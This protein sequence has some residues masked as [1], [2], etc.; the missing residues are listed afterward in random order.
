MGSILHYLYQYVKFGKFTTIFLIVIGVIILGKLL[1]KFRCTFSTR[2]TFLL[3]LLLGLS[4]RVGWLSYSS[5]ITLMEWNAGP[6][7]EFDWLNINAVELAQHGT[8]FHGPDGLPSGRRPIGYPLFLA[9]FYKIFGA[10]LVVAKTVNLGLYALTL[11]FLFKMA[12]KIFGDPAALI[13]SFLFAIYPMSIYSIG[14]LTDEHL[15]LPVWYGGLYLIFRILDGHRIKYDWLWLGIIFGYATMVRTHSIFMPFIVG[16]SF[17]FLK[18]PWK[19]VIVKIILVALVMQLINLPWVIRNYKVWKV[20]VLYTATGFFVYGA[21]N[22]TA[23][24]EGEGH[25]PAKGEPGYSPELDAAI[26]SGNEGLMHQIATR[27]MIKWIVNHPLQFFNLGASRL[28]NFMCFNRRSGIWAIWHQYYPGSF[29]PARPLPE[30][31]KKMLEEYAFAFYYILFFS[32]LFG[33]ILL[34]RRGQ[35]LAPITRRCLLILGL[36]FLFWFAEHMV[37]YPD[38]KYRFPLEPLMIII[39]A[40]FFYHLSIPP[41]ILESLKGLSTNLT[42]R[43]KR[44]SFFGKS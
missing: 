27:E 12:K 33:G 31:F 18:R 25:I 9:I 4:L 20:P 40:Y 42:D 39:S 30:R 38:R 6:K 8:W 1:F 10:H 7:Q 3:I 21:L 29:D 16:A 13:T 44:G 41:R 23:T 26:Q 35:L 34:L 14:L 37:I 5:H 36:C 2:T 17:W 32:W 22:S 28:L 19:E 15:F 24:P 11:V 43:L